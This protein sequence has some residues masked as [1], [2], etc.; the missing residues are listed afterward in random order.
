VSVAP[1]RI[2]VHP[3]DSTSKARTELEQHRTDLAAQ[4]AELRDRARRTE[5]RAD[6]ERAERLAGRQDRPKE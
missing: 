5:E 6:A 3:S 4:F 2:P 1:Q